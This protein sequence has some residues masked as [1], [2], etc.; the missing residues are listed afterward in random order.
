MQ[1]PKRLVGVKEGEPDQNTW[2]F[3]NPD[4]TG[5]V[6]RKTKL[7]GGLLNALFM[8]SSI[9]PNLALSI[10]HFALILIVPVLTPVI[11]FEALCEMTTLN[12]DVYQRRVNFFDFFNTNRLD[13]WWNAVPYLLPV[14]YLHIYVL[15]Y[16]FFAY[17][18]VLSFYLTGL[19]NNGKF[20]VHYTHIKKFFMY[21]Y[22]L[23]VSVFLFLYIAMLWFALVWA[24]LASILNPSVF[25]PYTAAALT[26]VATI[27]AKSVEYRKK[28]ENL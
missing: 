24:V 13:P 1:P 25:L 23:S 3:L 22:Y 16:L 21:G 7:S 5:I 19:D 9:V 10:S 17:V 11:T 4:V 14:A 15:V 2:W 28:Y 12:A 18:E 27:T 6:K 20:S 26:L 8:D